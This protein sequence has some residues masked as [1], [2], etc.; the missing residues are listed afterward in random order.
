MTLTLSSFKVVKNIYHI[1]DGQDQS[2]QR[3]NGTALWQQHHCACNCCEPSQCVSVLFCLVVGGV[4]CSMGAS[5]VACRLLAQEVVHKLLLLERQLPLCTCHQ[6]ES[7]ASSP[8]RD[9]SEHRDQA[10]LLGTPL[11]RRCLPRVACAKGF[12]TARR[13]ARR[14]LQRPFVQGVRP[15]MVTTLQIE[16]GKS[17]AAQKGTATAHSTAGCPSSVTEHTASDWTHGLVESMCVGATPQ[18]AGG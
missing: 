13:P 7:S 16:H 11:Y 14:A 9:P 4:V 15:F 1:L 8:E 17:L 10:A 2:L 5:A 6:C 18:R 12:G 3:G